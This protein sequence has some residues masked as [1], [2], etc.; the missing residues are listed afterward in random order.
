MTTRGSNTLRQSPGLAFGLFFIMARAL[1]SMIN[2]IRPSASAYE[3]FIQVA[4][5]VLLTRKTPVGRGFGRSI[6]V[7]GYRNSVIVAEYAEYL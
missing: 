7:F 2:N 3:I 1:G 5:T 4:I 6:Q